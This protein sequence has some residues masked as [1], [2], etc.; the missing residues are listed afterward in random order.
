MVEHGGRTVPR[1]R[2]RCEDGAHWRHTDVSTAS[3]N[4]REQRKKG[5]TEMN[6][7]FAMARVDGECF[8]ANAE[9]VVRALMRGAA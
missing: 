6:E 4:T 8:V 3:E 7:Q 2:A 9:D 5:S 1:M